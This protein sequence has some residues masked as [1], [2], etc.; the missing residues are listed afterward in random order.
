MENSKNPAMG[1][2]NPDLGPEDG[3]SW[4]VGTIWT[5]GVAC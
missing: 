3:E 1:G 5:P 4:F 2:G